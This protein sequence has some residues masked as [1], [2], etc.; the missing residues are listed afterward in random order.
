M[1]ACL[2]K[3]ADRDIGVCQVELTLQVVGVLCNDGFEMGYR[4][5]VSACYM[6]DGAQV[7]ANRNIFGIDLGRLL[8]VFDTLLWLPKRSVCAAK[9]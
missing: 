2:V 3:L 7:V 6:K 5:L 1:P 8:K 9:V 4:F